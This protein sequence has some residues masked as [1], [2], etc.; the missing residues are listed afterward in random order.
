MLQGI[1][2]EES[3]DG[4]AYGHVYGDA[5]GH[6]STVTPTLTATPTDTATP[7]ETPTE[8]PTPTATATETAYLG[9]RAGLAAPLMEP[10]FAP[11]V[12]PLAQPVTT[13]HRIISYTYDSLYRLTDAEYSTG[14][15]Y[16]YA[17]DAVG[18]RLSLVTSNGSTSYEYDAANRLTSVNGVV[19]TWDA[20]GNLLSDGVRSYS[21]DHANRLT[22]VVSGTLT[23][24]FTYNGAGDR[25]AKT[26]DGVTTDYVLDPAAG[27]TQVLVE[28]T[29]GQQT[30]YLYGLDLLAQYDSGTW[31]YHVNDGLGSVR[32]LADPAGQ[33]VQGYS[34]SPFGMPLGESGGEPYG[35]T[36][37]QWESQA[38]LLYLR[39]RYYQPRMGRFITEDPFPGL[40]GQPQTLNQFVYVTNN[41]VN[42]VDPKGLYG[43][44][45]HHDLTFKW[46][47]EM[48]LRCGCDPCMSWV[49][50]ELIAQADLW[51]DAKL[52][53]MLPVPIPIIGQPERHFL[54]RAQA[55][56]DINRA[57]ESRKV[58]RFGIAL[59]QLQ[60][61]FSHWEEGYVLQM[62]TDY[63]HGL[64]GLVNWL[65]PLYRDELTELIDGCAELLVQKGY[66]KSYV[67]KLSD[68][69]VLD[70]F[71]REYTDP[72]S[73]I[74]QALGYNTDLYSPWS[75]RDKDME[76]ATRRALREFFTLFGS[77]RC[78]LGRAPQGWE[79]M[80]VPVDAWWVYRESTQQCQQQC[81]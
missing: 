33:V 41:S 69:D 63:G 26:V 9:G 32:Q 78:D 42:R 20:N 39:A 31:A 43:K 34:F 51:V 77:A 48:A 24:E 17:Y 25:V 6:H 54:T 16:Q 74:R 13:T 47:G 73:P 19:Y 29:G 15:F 3:T 71:L 55:Q 53:G 36:G 22:Q 45:V 37:E 12:A 64:T 66:P 38:E 65:R 49:H 60:D 27:L 61:T 21:Y 81:K 1:Y 68:D 62:E 40:R 57:I 5:Y 52:S 30:A 70:L 44:D 58:W 79:W 14:E 67:E 28:S 23:T 56:R 4:Y 10:E 18:N 75:A 76:V 59:H 2:L 46:A 8:E 11:P 72:N 50:A 80:H 7:T 35:F